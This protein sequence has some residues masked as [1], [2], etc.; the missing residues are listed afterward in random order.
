MKLAFIVN[1][2]NG[3]TGLERMTVSQANHFLENYNYQIDII[4]LNQ[5]SDDRRR[6]YKLNNKIKTHF[7]NIH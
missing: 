5:K 1:E 6:H 7:L 4:L 3:V 2:I